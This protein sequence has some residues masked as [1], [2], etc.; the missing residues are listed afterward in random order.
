[1]LLGIDHAV[2][3]V[4]DPDAAAI[5]LADS[6]GL[7]ANGGGRHE[8]LGTFNR[9]VWL[10]DSYLELIGVFDRAL[11][12]T[13]WLGRPTLASLDGGPL[14][15]ARTRPD[16]RVVRW[17]LAHPPALSAA[18]PFFIEHD[19]TAAEWTPA[20]RTERDAQVH[21]VGGRVRLLGLDLPTERSAADAGALRRLLAT[22]VEPDGRRAV[23]VG[24]GRQSV[25]FGPPVDGDAVPAVELVTDVPS[26][27]RTLRVGGCD[28]R[29]VGHAPPP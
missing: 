17:R 16:G 10:G 12:A 9:L 29:L 18:V 4:D 5:A 22:S 15:G 8:R 25:R 21:P 2:I 27:R 23:R 3:A 19:P 7:A 11:A 26:R 20:E 28:I 1:M 13:T 24:V 14:D 6:L